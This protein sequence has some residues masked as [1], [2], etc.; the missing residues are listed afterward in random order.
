ME[1]AW[2]QTKDNRIRIQDVRSQCGSRH[3]MLTTEYNGQWDVA[4]CRAVL[5]V[6][7]VVPPISIEQI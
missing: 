2:S 5:R 7:P 6:T 4:H 3:E 1:Q